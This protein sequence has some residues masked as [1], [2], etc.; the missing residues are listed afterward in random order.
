MSVLF[1]TNIYFFLSVS[2]SFCHT[3]Y[4]AFTVQRAPLL[5]NLVLKGPTAHA[6]LS[7]MSLSAPLVME[8]SI[9]LVWD[10]QSPLE[11]AKTASSVEGEPSPQYENAVLKIYSVKGVSH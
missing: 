9:A 10:S 7:V 4:R 11:F 1:T 6:P 3:N 2:F 8:A 5:Q